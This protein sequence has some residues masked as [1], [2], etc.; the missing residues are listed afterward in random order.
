MGR[1][2]AR[3]LAQ[4]GANVILVARNVDKLKAAVAYI[5]SVCYYIDSATLDGEVRSRLSPGLTDLG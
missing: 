1:G 4:K 2:V 5:S 3:L